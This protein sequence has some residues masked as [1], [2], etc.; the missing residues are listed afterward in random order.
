MLGTARGVVKVLANKFPSEQAAAATAQTDLDATIAS[1]GTLLQ[2][3]TSADIVAA[4]GAGIQ[5]L[6]DI[7]NSA[8]PTSGQNNSDFKWLGFLGLFCPCQ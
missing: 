5:A 8:N 4:T 3:G 2:Y 7:S 6:E 1:C